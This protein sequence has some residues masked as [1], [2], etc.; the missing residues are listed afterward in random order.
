MTSMTLAFD[1]LARDRASRVLNDVGGSADRTGGKLAKMGKVAALGGAAVAAGAVI[2]GKALF[3][4]AKGAAEDE[5]GQ[6][7]LA[8]ALNNATGATGKQ[9]AGVESWITAQGKALGVADDQLRPTM[10]KLAIATGSVGKAQRLSSLAMDISA[11][12]GKSLEQVSTALAKAQNG[13][14]GGLARLG[15]ATKDADG[16]T[17]S[18]KAITEDLAKAYSGQASAAADTTAGKWGRLKLQFDETKESIGAKLLPLGERLADW[19]LNDL[20]PA[21]EKAG[22]WF[23]ENLLPPMQSFAEKI[24]PKIQDVIGK[25]KQGFADA[26]PFF[27]LVGKVFQNVLAPALTKAAEI[28]FPALGAQL[29]LLGKAFGLLGTAATFMW[30]NAVAPALRFMATAVSTLATAW[31]ILLRAIGNVPGFGW[32]T[33]AAEKLETVATRAAKAAENIKNIDTEKNVK[34]NVNVVTKVSG[35]AAGQANQLLGSL[36]L[37]SNARGTKFWRG[38]LTWVG[39]EGAELINAP[40]GSRIHTATESKRMSESGGASAGSR[41]F[42]FHGIQDLRLMAMAAAR[43]EAYAGV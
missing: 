3:D 17:R 40:R 16:K 41:E 12:S 11:G 31:S 42:H 7:R 23:K 28:Y 21:A 4:M 26:Q 24:G 38:G 32:A 20:A 10:E 27:D 37:G 15:V 39:E 14:V 33:T 29:S 36:G 1:I 25:V 8:K 9:V 18:L 2:A 22:M 35:A 19:L 43:E 34:I 30:N 13:N 6:V 5:A